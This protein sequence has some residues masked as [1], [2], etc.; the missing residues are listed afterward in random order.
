MTMPAAAPHGFGLLDVLLI[1]GGLMIW[2]GTVLFALASH[3]NFRGRLELQH[4][5]VWI[6]LGRPGFSNWEGTSPW[7][8][9][10][11][12][13]RRRYLELRDPELTRR[14]NRALISRVVAIVV[15]VSFAAGATWRWQ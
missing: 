10:G 13:I 4:R 1:Y 14:G 3:N 9:D 11:Y 7:A 15:I 8:L 2:V 5:D 12:L 6:A